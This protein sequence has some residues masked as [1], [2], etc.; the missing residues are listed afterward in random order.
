MSSPVVC[1]RQ[2]ETLDNIRYIINTPTLRHNGYP[3]VINAES[4]SKVREY[5]SGNESNS[6]VREMLTTFMSH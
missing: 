2:Y 3:V 1:V 6:K 4:N 5:I